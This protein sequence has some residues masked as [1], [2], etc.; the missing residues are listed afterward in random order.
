MR[1]LPLCVRVVRAAVC[2]APPLA[3]LGIL[4]G[5]HALF[6]FGPTHREVDAPDT[7]AE[8]DVPHVEADAAEA[9]DAVDVPDDGADETEPQ[10]GNDIVEG[11]EAC[12]GD[13]P[14]FCLT[15]C[16][17]NGA[18]TCVDCIWQPC[19]AVEE[20]N[21]DDDDCDT[22]CD[23]T[24]ACCRGRVESCTTSCGSIGSRSC[25]DRCSWGFCSPPREVC[26]AV[27]DDCDTVCDNTYE[28]CRGATDRCATGCGTSGSRTCSDA[29]TWEPCR[30]P[31]EICDGVD[32]D[33]DTVCDNDFDCCRLRSE[34]CATSCGSI[35][36]RVCSVS[37]A[38]GS[39]APPIEAC[40]GRDDDC[41]TVCDNGSPCCANAAISCTTA[42]GTP[43]TQICSAACSLP[44]QC[45]APAEICG[46]SCDDN[47]A[48]GIDEGC[49]PPCAGATDVSAGGRFTGFLLPGAGTTGGACGGDGAEAFFTFTTTT[50]RDM[51]L[52]THSSSFDTVLYVRRC[53]CD[54]VQ[55]ACNDDADGLPTS[56]LSLGDLPAGVYHVFVDA[57]DAAG[58]GSFRLDAYFTEPAAA[59]DRCGKPIRVTTAGAT[60][61]SCAFSADYTPVGTPG[62]PFVGSGGAKDLVYY[63]VLAS[64]ATVRF[65]TCASDVYCPI[66][67]SCFDTTLYLREVCTSDRPQPACNDD[68]CGYV[69]GAGD[70]IQ[71]DTGPVTLGAGLYYFFLDGYDDGNPWYTC[72]DYVL[73]VTGL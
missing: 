24:F 13:P 5:C 32:Q 17:T 18:Q 12:D 65:E 10:C 51:F 39:C 62:C 6:D 2:C 59:G 15:T 72:G 16:S 29:C 52:T 27:D 44:A 69:T 30:P 53:A 35:G 49:C 36:S 67:G 20:C 37:C 33:C 42:C 64:P 60:G 3:A 7:D 61:N 14:R 1:S 50:V 43:G 11:S 55:V 25:N 23:D 58:G 66:V 34:P 9:D 71:S 73:R 48:G 41:D 54:G 56:V 8:A 70:Q 28:C 31:P 38:W 4:S 57:K 45:C 22:V 63:F 47:C 21:G 19:E 46:N 68:V 40:N 26:N